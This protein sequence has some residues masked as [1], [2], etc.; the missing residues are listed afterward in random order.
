[1]DH[2]ED[3]SISHNSNGL[4]ADHNAKQADLANDP[5]V[6]AGKYAAESNDVD[7]S[8]GEFEHDS[9]VTGDRDEAKQESSEK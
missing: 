7:R 1:M 2:A 5:T 3:F 9:Y 4:A 8:V 6:Q